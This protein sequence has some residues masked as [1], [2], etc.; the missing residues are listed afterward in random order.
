MAPYAH[1]LAAYWAARGRTNTKVPC[2]ICSST[3][4]KASEPC[5]SIRVD[6]GKLLYHCHHCDA[7]GAVPLQD[8]QSRRHTGLT[9]APPPPLPVEQY[10]A[11]ATEAVWEWLH[12]RG[13]DKDI[14]SQHPALRDDPMLAVGSAPGHDVIAFPMTKSN[15][16]VVNV[17]Y[18]SLVDKRFRLIKGRP[19]TFYLRHTMREGG[20]RI[21]ITEGQVDA[22]SMLVALP[23][24]VTVIS[25]PN[26][27]N[28]MSFD[29]DAWAAV[30]SWYDEVVIATDGD[31][32]GQQAAAAIAKRVGYHKARTVIWPDGCKDAND[33][34][35]RHGPD[36][37]RRVVDNAMA[38]PVEGVLTADD[39]LPHITRKLDEWPEQR[40]ANSGMVALDEMVRVAHGELVLIT[41]VPGHGKSTFIDQWTVGLAAHSEWRT[42][43]LS[44]EKYD[45]AT[46]AVELMEKYLGKR[47]A[48][49]WSKEYAAL[50]Y[51]EKPTLTEVEEAV[52]FINKH[53]VFFDVSS[54]TTNENIYNIDV[55]IDKLQGVH[56]RFNIDLF[57][58]DNLSFVERTGRNENDSV[59]AILN[60]LILFAKR[61]DVCIF[62]VAHPRKPDSGT[63]ENYVPRGYSVSG[64]ANLF[65][66]VDIGLTIYRDYESNQTNVYKWKQRDKYA[67]D[68]RIKEVAFVFDTETSIFKAMDF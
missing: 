20:R 33:V 57:V 62:I 12:G 60:K 61:H 6:G 22:L 48:G 8:D 38:P 68:P 65:N 32:P 64:T 35:L 31:A 16:E 49:T 21:V 17:Q 27:S 40:R 39:M 36:M 54:R 45:H 1:E 43:F 34:L 19:L 67:G 2:P 50:G 41:G 63:G 66:K 51:T 18:R 47:V 15:G 3:R 28:N 59:N 30:A 4:K 5:L 58:L 55:I 11:P 14:I 10:L 7:R 37:L 23:H 52:A 29:P 44:F 53:F 42:A 46:H 25:L 26:G 56:H 24:D 9:F 13:I